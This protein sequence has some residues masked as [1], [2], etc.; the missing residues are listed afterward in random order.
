[1]TEREGSPDGPPREHWAAVSAVSAVSAVP[2]VPAVP[3]VVELREVNE[4][5]LIAGL[6]EQELA[7]ALEGER[8]QLAVILTSIGDAVLVVDRDGHPVLTNAAYARMMETLAVVPALETADGQPLTHEDAPWGR[9][10]GG[11]AFAVEFGAVAA[12]GT[13]RW[14]EARGR[15]ISHAPGASAMGSVVIIRDISVR[16]GLEGA[17]QHQALH[18][19]LTG[20]P[21]RT[22][23]HDR[24]DQALRSAQ[25]GAEPPAL[26][27]LDLDHFKEINDTHGHQAGDRLLQE[28]AARLTRT[29]RGS[30]TVARLGG[31]EFAILLPE[32]GRA[33]AVEVAGAIRAGLTPV[34][35]VEEQG[36]HVAVSIGI[37]F[38]AGRDTDAQ[39]LLRHADVAMYDAKRTR[40]GHAIYSVA[41][42]QH[43]RSALALASELGAAIAVGQLVVHYQPKLRLGPSLDATGAIGLEEGRIDGVEALVRWVH[44][45]RGLILP[46]DFIPLAER[47]GLII[48][49]TTWVLEAAL[50]Q[51][52][53]WRRAGQTLSL[54]VNLSMANLRD[55]D[56]PDT[57]TRLL[58]Q[59]AFPATMLRLE[60]TESMIMADPSGSAAA[61]AR[62]VDLGA[63]S[64]IDDFG[65]GYSSLAYLKRLPV[66]EIKIDRSFVEHASAVATDAAI[67]QAIVTLGHGLGM[68][69]V[70]EG[71]EDQATLDLVERLGCDAVQGHH[72]SPP[73]AATDVLDWLH[74]AAWEPGHA[75]APANIPP[76]QHGHD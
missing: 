32:T 31:D 39:L 18:D 65:T 19:A 64:A 47:T 73:L 11:D 26:L 62:L 59:Y 1:M 30:D 49:L 8:A 14:W 20:L 48:P 3:A 25:R 13:R 67:I 33:G 71:V 45:E 23:L 55:P 6:R 40:S 10:A 60:L 66:D 68:R 61:L 4:R 50:R 24:L 46:D 72:V 42:D 29:V 57:I 37:A 16:K 75:G 15:P 7:A 9:A 43:N 44:P 27:L 56:L 17:L 36:L 76:D 34:I 28:V 35:M 74:G 63:H 54:A 70:A 52:R 12:D 58:T 69:I 41:R 38:A 21:N 22:L 51:A 53:T 5:L 2:A